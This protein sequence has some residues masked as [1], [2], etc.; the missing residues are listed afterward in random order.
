MTQEHRTT[1]LSKE[2]VPY[3]PLKEGTYIP[4]KLPVGF[5]RAP[6]AMD[7]VAT[8]HLS[9]NIGPQHPSTH[10]VLRILSEM[11]GE[12][13]VGAEMDIGFLHR[14]IEKLAEHRTYPM[15]G[16]LLDRG[17]Y[18]SGIH[19]E[20][21]V[22]L[23][24]E[25]LMDVDVPEKAKWIRV[26]LG[27]MTRVTS[28]LIYYGT[29]G[30]DSGSMGPF[31]Y[32]MREREPLIDMIEAVTG[33]RM[34][35]NY[36]RPG[37]VVEDLPADL[38]G[39]LR[40]FLKTYFDYMDEHEA[41]LADNEIF[42]ARTRGVAQVDGEM[43]LAFGLT[44]PN[45]RASGVPYDLRKAM[46]Y[47][48]YDQLDFQINVREGG[49]LYDRFMLRLDEMR[50]SGRLMQQVLDG[51]P[52]GPTMAKMPRIIKPPA[53][54]AYAAVESPRGEWGIHLVSDGTNQ[55]SRMRYRPPCLYSL[56]LIEAIM[57][58]QLLADAL[59]AAGSFDLVLGEVDR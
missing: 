35:F 3:R 10:G 39:K 6:S 57:P 42:R 26:L 40:A 19:G 59:L 22:A 32:A 53:G 9:L 14:G 7:E 47:D 50:L 34:M 8:E 56:Q 52:E 25:K 41:I 44:G 29:L 48:A 18:V 5:K 17:D 28:T 23:A 46:P 58:G 16:T 12:Y 49:D 11:D 51:M 4:D 15:L 31:L 30:L 54:E 27:E 21:A 1:I 13:I 36:V 55:P 2:Q 38:E 45:L 43:A 33:S 24:T 20:I 37:G